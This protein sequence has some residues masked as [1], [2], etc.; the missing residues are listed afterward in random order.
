MIQPFMLDY[1]IGAGIFILLVIIQATVSVV[2]RRERLDWVFVI[3]IW[4]IF[5]FFILRLLGVV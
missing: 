2:Y 5:I 4:S 3:L 1:D